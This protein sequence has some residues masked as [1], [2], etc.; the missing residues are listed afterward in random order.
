[1]YSLH[2]FSVRLMWHPVSNSEVVFQST[3]AHTPHLMGVEQTA[4]KP[5]AFIVVH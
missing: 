1:M 4:F 3:S 2:F 5:L